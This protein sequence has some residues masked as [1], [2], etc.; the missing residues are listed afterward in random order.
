MQND[1]LKWLIESFALAIPWNY[2]QVS[3]YKGEQFQILHDNY[4]LYQNL[5][6]EGRAH[7]TEIW[8]LLLVLRVGPRRISSGKKTIILY[9]VSTKYADCNLS[10]E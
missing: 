3:K 4:I 2:L 6:S 9:K 1:I 5:R 7:Y 8:M 10:N